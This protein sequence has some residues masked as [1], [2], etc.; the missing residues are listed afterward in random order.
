MNRY[1]IVGNEIE[2]YFDTKPSAEIR[3]EMKSIKIW[4]NPDKK[5]WHSKNTPEVLALAKKLCE[6]KDTN[7]KSIPNNTARCCYYN[8]IDNFC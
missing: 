4:W 8:S 6:F 1:K 5:C 3:T 2:I 7:I